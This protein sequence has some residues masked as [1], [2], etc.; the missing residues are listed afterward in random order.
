MFLILLNG[1]YVLKLDKLLIVYTFGTRRKN[2]NESPYLT[3][4]NEKTS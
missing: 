2:Q 4:V 3:T 1:I